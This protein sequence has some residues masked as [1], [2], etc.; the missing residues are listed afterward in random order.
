MINENLNENNDEFETQINDIITIFFNQLFPKN[1]IEKS[2][3]YLFYIKENLLWKTFSIS[4][5]N[6][7]FKNKKFKHLKQSFFFL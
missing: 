5:K 1:I 2:M 3:G 6:I 7:L 4:S